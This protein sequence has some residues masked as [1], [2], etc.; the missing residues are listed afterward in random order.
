[1]KRSAIVLLSAAAVLSV[2][3]GAAV[4]YKYG[5]T[6][7]EASVAKS[8]ETFLVRDHAPV[9]GRKD[10]PVTIVEFFDPSCESCR[11]FYPAVKKIL[12][13]Y[14][15][16]VRLVLRYA[17]FHP[18]SDEAVRILE[19]A[20][21]QDKFVPVLEALLEQQPQWA[22][23]GAPDLAKAWAAAGA[24]GLDLERARRDAGRPEFDEVLR[25]DAEDVKAAGVNGT[26]TFFVNGRPL[27]S[28]G[29]QQLE[30]L[31]ASEVTAARRPQ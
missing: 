23:H 8:N 15:G 31:V 21:L 29:Q 13:T 20:R 1:M 30:D 6:T 7:S 25:K 17:A 12:A 3:L 28:F 16:E 9:V 24:A 18:G 11:A 27:P 10:A 22:V 14:A 19:A 5:V 26:P 2:F 4:V